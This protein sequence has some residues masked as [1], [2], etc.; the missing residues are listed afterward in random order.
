MAAAMIQ[1]GDQVPHFE[2]SALDG[3]R[4]RYATIW[5]HRNLVL[6]RVPSSA[7]EA[8]GPYASQLADA[9]RQEAGGDADCVVTTDDIAGVPA[10]AVVIADRWGEVMHVAAGETLAA[11]PASEDV[12]EWVR[13]VRARCAE[14]EGE[15]K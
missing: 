9:V 10:P 6:L 4:V 11:L 8:A 14:C 7:R 13:Y 1:R 3:Q 12:A 15:A 5:Q 2:V